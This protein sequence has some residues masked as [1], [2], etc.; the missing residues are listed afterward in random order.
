MDKITKTVKTITSMFHQTKKNDGA[1]AVLK[2]KAW[3][4]LWSRPLLINSDLL[5]R[6]LCMSALRMYSFSPK[7]RLHVF[8]RAL[9]ALARSWSLYVPDIL[10]YIFTPILRYLC[11]TF[12]SIEL[13]FT[14]WINFDFVLLSQVF[15]YFLAL[16][17]FII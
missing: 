15:I 12:F 4:L 11:T 16:L 10:G 7:Q 9:Y 14:E 2:L 17:Q 8:V 1:Y 5:F 3:N 13:S 6:K